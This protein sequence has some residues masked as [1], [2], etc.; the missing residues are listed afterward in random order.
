MDFIKKRKADENGNSIPTGTT[1]S[2]PITPLTPEEIRKII[3]PFTKDQLLDILQSATLQHSD[4]LNSVRSVADGDISLRK[5]FIRGLSSETTS[6]TLRILFSSSGELEEAIVIHDKNTGKSKGFGFITFKHVDA[7]MLSIREPSKKID[8]RITVTQ[9]AS[10]NSSTTDVSLRKVYVGNVPFEVSSERLLGF[11]S[12][13]GEIEEGPLGFDK[14]TGKSK[15]F[16]FLIYKNEEGAKAAIADPMKNIDG[17]QVVCKFAADN[18]KVNKNSQVGAITQTSQPLTY[19]PL[20][21]NSQNYGPASTNSYQMNT[22]M[23]GSGYNGSYRHP[24]YLGAGLN[25]GGLNNAGALM[26]RMP[27]ASGSGVYPDTG[28]YALP[29]HQQPSSMSMS[30]SMQPRLPHGAGGM[31]QGMPPYY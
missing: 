4:V 30:M 3:E 20:T 2:S 9:L 10:N 1:P 25:D 16:A 18:R 19:P 23:T 26:Y 22:S 29:Q 11:F 21:G 5:L 12:M 27:Q 24:P 13:Y 15:G 28:S 14:S 31:Y 17:H 8:G 7:A 6:E